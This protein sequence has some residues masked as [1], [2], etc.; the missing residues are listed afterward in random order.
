M[1][2]L[3]AVGSIVEHKTVS[4]DETAAVIDVE[5]KIKNLTGLRDRLRKMLDSTTNAGFK[6]IVEVDRELT[7]AKS[8]LDSLQT[9]RKALANETEKVSV[10]ITFSA[11]ESLARPESLRRCRPPG[12][13]G[14]SPCRKCRVAI[15]FAVWAIPWLVLFIPALWLSVK[16]FGK[17]RGE[18]SNRWR[19]RRDK[20]LRNFHP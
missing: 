7:K 8:E 5:A 9:T 3:E 12:T 13:A 16:A 18:K 1:K 17:M 2:R 6:D 11:R 14:P 19:R 20:R 15:V 10:A 4:A